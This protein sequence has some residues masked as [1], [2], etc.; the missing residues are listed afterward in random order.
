MD[1]GIV[2]STQPKHPDQKRLV[3]EKAYLAQGLSATY[4]GP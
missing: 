2:P 1:Q 3:Y 4:A